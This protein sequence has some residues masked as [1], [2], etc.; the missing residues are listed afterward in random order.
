MHNMF[1]HLYE[2]PVRKLFTMHEPSSYI[3][4]LQNL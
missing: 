3:D 2:L 1:N 4:S